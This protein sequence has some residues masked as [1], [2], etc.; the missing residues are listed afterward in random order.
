MTSITTHTSVTVLGDPETAGAFDSEGLDSGITISSTRTEETATGA[1]FA[2]TDC[3]L[4]D[5]EYLGEQWQSVLTEVLEQNPDLPI[6]L[7][8]AADFQET[9]TQA[10]DAGATDYL[11]RSLCF[12]QPETVL[13]RI[14]RAVAAA[15]PMQNA[16]FDA[17]D[18]FRLVTENVDEIIYITNADFSE[19]DFVNDAY[20][21]IWGRPVAE[22]YENATAF[23]EGIDPRD[24]AEFLEDFEAMRADIRRGEPEDS[25][26]FEFRVRHE[27]GEIRWVMATGYP[28]TVDGGPDRYVGIVE[29][30]TERHEL[31]QTYREVFESVSDGLVVHDPETGEIRDVN[32]RY[33]TL[34]GYEKDELVGSD[35]QMIVPEDAE[36]TVETAMERIEAAREE[37]PQ[38]FEFVGE[39]RDGERFTGEIHLSTATIRGEE[40]VL[41]SVRDVTDRTRREQAIYELQEATERM[42]T[43]D[44]AEQAA[45]VAV[46]TAFD[47]LGVPMSICWLHDPETGVLEPVAATEDV[48]DEGLISPISSDRYEY[49]VFQEGR[50]TTYTPNEVNPENPLETA[51][52]LPLGEHGLI[53]AG[54]PTATEYDG[55][56][57]NIART[58][59]EHTETALDR[60]ARERE[61]RKSQQRMQAIIDRIDE[62]IF[63]APVSELDEGQPAPDYVSSGY[64]EIWGQPLE[65]LHE[66]YE[67]GFFGTLHPDEYEG[68]RA[69]IDRIADDVAS[70]AADDRYS[71]EYR[72]E[73][74]D[75]EVRWVHSDFYPT[76][77]GSEETRIVIVSRDVTERRARQRAVENFHDA[78]A[79]LTTAGTVTEAADIAV[80]AAADVFDISAT[81]VFHYDRN[82]TNLEPRASGPAVP[83]PSELPELSAADD[84]AWES[85]VDE[86]MQFVDS[87]EVPSLDVGHGTEVL[88]FPLGGNGLLVVWRSEESLDT[89][90]VGILAATL[91]AALNR[92]RERSRLETH[93]AELETQ[94]ER[95][96]RFEAITEVTQRV[97]AAITSESTR[98]GIYDAVCAELA[99]VEPFEAA[100][101]GAAEVGADQLTPRTVAGV[102]RDTVE[103]ALGGHGPAETDPHP[104]IEVWQTGEPVAINDLV[105]SSPQSDWRQSLR[106]DGVASICAV[107]LAHGGITYSVLTILAEEPDAFGS[108]E[109]EVLSQLGTSIGY[110]ITAIERQRALESDATLELEFQ[111]TDVALPFAR[112]AR[113]PPCDVRHERT[114][115]RPDGSVSVYY[116]LLS[117]AVEEVADRA[118]E[119]LPGDVDVV[120]KQDGEVVLERRG[121]SWFGALISEYGGVLRRGRATESG[122]ELVVELP[123]ETDTRTIVDRIQ[124]EFPSLELTAQRHHRETET[125]PGVAQNR[126]EQRLTDR[127]Y[128]AIETA[129]AMGYFDWPRESSGEDVAE[130]L[131]I[132]QPTVN[133]HIRLGER[134]VFDLLFGADAATSR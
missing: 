60:I 58:L 1:D 22:L 115:R 33:C 4:L 75:G 98:Q 54:R 45:E 19:V 65:G 95:A 128:E 34:T 15:P 38:L 52:L 103:R 133:K 27:D 90:A 28:V 112:L 70:G 91:E 127:Q 96:R 69:L 49:D 55:V 29:D 81:A 101:I 84:H 53:A 37:G 56:T 9:I 132:T 8:V 134:K 113:D 57:I 73:Q 59:A 5:Q 17:Q 50:I 67:E 131:G 16:R 44:S 108:R 35:V 36:F 68:Y 26:E 63:L 110:A 116:T 109:M 86:T 88:L 18:R 111:G 106:K 122:V 71:R 39:R 11:P 74:P 126:L 7:L 125:T 31:E 48:R 64:E 129:H 78:T 66:T 42:Q 117:D 130:S 40:Q 23:V 89:N 118:P 119:T 99:G 21:T 105:G 104:A 6:I 97:E 83:D 102:G 62:A 47:A 123:R 77:W 32:D 12:E 14:E 76:S 92:L 46:E 93:Q 107:P 51:I 94:T 3:L 124:E 100:W 121:S 72:I 79:Q 30:V 43:A 41:A 2:D 20:E 80:E 13:E 87:E 114:I 25:Y 61:V 24:R 85:F 10:V 120:S 82:A